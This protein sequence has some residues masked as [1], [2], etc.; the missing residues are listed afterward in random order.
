[1]VKGTEDPRGLRIPLPLLLMLLMVLVIISVY[2][3]LKK[4]QDVH[5]EANRRVARAVLESTLTRANSGLND[6]ASRIASQDRPFDEGPSEVVFRDDITDVEDLA[7]RTLFLGFDTQYRILEGRIGHITLG[8][9]VLADLASQPAFSRLF[10]RKTA[11][12]RL[13]NTLLFIVNSVPFILSDPHPLRTS[14]Q[15]ERSAFLVIGLPA[16]DMVFDELQKYEVFESGALKTHLEK[17]DDISGLAELIVSL[18]ER[19]YAQFHFSAVAQ[20]LVLLVAFVIAVIIGRHIDAKNEDL[21]QSRDLIA[22]REREAQHLRHLAEQASEAKS[23]LIQNMSHELRTPLNAV[24]GFSE[25]LLKQMFGPLG[26][27]RYLSYVEDIHGSSS[28][29]LGI[30]NSI[31]DLSR[32]EAGKFT[33]NEEEVELPCVLDQ[34][35]RMFRERAADQDISLTVDLPVHAILLRA[36]P[37]LLS[38]VIINLLSNAFKFTPSGGE[39]SVRL[40]NEEGGGCQIRID[41]TGIGISNE[42]LSKVIEPFV[43]VEGAFNRKYEGTGLG[44][45]LSKRMMELHGG[46]LEIDSKLGEGTSATI[47]F[48]ADRV[49][50]LPTSVKYSP[51]QAV[52]TA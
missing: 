41:D 30:L 14:G 6:I 12:S 7:N 32:A 16:R 4:S 3:I 17:Q 10:T 1:M 8:T 11:V 9:T 38:Q 40:A 48:P 13:S 36:D 50:T 2:D 27:D 43:Q 51:A 15:N 21:R 35:L 49:I 26:S 52:G 28:H 25:I 34:C 24:I 31:L 39:I 37:Q 46:N 5:S 20:I 18:Q 23:Q 47:R 19:E 22:E 44:L 33:L 29:L 42:D 45:P